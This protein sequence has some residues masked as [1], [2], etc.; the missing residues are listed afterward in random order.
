MLAIEVLLALAVIIIG[1][2]GMAFS[3]AAASWAVGV[4]GR[5]VR[6]TIGENVYRVGF[7]V[8]G[9]FFVTFGV[10]MAILIA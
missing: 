6:T 10:L 3:R 5:L 9:A 8:V 4:D 2:Y 1:I 7:M